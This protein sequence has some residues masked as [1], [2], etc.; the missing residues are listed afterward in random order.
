MSLSEII[1]YYTI[2]INPINNKLHI[3]R[4]LY[5]RKKKLQLQVTGID[6]EDEPFFSTIINEN[7]V[8]EGELADLSF[9]YY[10]V[11][12]F[13]QKCIQCTPMGVIKFSTL[14]FCD[15]CFVLWHSM[16][17]FFLKPLFCSNDITYMNIHMGAGK[18]N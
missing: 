2:D 6:Y 10:S 13:F 11:I 8:I 16:C 17:S 5:L 14:G 1:A 15:R 7:I 12:L 3:R 4:D 9:Y 18:Y